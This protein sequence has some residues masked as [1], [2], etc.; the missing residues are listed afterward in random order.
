MHGDHGSLGE[1]GPDVTASVKTDGITLLLTPQGLAQANRSLKDIVRLHQ[2]V[3][4]TK[5]VLGLC[6]RPRHH[7]GFRL[8]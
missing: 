3:V 8:P 7:M 5:Q 4:A 2:G 1:P 6:C